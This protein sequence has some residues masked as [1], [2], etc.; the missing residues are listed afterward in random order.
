MFVFFQNPAGSTIDYHCDE[1]FIV[2]VSKWQPREWEPRSISHWGG[3][4]PAEMV[5]G[6]GLG[7]PG[8]PG[9]GGGGPP[10]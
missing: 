6:S 2:D 9:A 5:G 10:R 3:P 4:P 1:D 7:Q 8:A